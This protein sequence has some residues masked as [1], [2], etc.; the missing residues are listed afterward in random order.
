MP[1]TVFHVMLFLP[2]F[3]F[4][5]LVLA[6]F[7]GVRRA[8]FALCWVPLVLFVLI[9]VLGQLSVYSPSHVN[10]PD[11]TQAVVWTG[12][13]QCGLGVALGAR[14]ARRRQSYAGLL[15]ATC[16]AA[17]PYLLGNRV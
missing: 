3:A 13:A 6:T 15:V 7:Y 11:V 16:L 17:T 1:S 12:L 14:A 5:F 4:A 10:W 2:S 8:Y 9:K